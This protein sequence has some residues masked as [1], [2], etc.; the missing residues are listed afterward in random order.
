MTRYEIAQL[1]LFCRALWW[2]VLGIGSL[3]MM[4]AYAGLV[5]FAY[6]DINGCDPVKAGV[7][8]DL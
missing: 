7:K 2:N 6:Y 1:V 4:C 3:L 8:F 5:I